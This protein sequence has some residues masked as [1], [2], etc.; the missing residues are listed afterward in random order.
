[1]ISKTKVVPIRRLSIPRLELCGAYL[2]AQLLH[3]VQQVCQLPINSVHAWTD[4][5][6]VLN[7][8]V[9][10]PQR[11]KTYNVGNVVSC[12]VDL[13]GPERWNH[14]SG[15]KNSAGCAFRGLFPSELLDMVEW[16]HMAQIDWPRQ[17]RCPPMSGL[18]LSS[19]RL[20][21][22]YK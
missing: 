5:T 9:G 6:I 7:W 16:S 3:H 10:S 12:I 22:K 11:F 4:S 21:R 14:V 17:S 2:L 15:I 1:M 18:L 20:F 19:K 13:I 8:L